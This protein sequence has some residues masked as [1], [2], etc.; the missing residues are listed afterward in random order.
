MLLFALLIMTLIRCAPDEISDQLNNS[1]T[2]NSDQ[3]TLAKAL[4]KA[5]LR[6]DVRAFL[7]NEALKQFDEDFD[8]LYHMIKDKEVSQGETFESILQACSDKTANISSITNSMPLLTIFIPDLPKFSVRSWDINASPS[9]LV[10]IRDD[11]AGA[12]LFDSN[13]GHFKMNVKDY[14]DFPVIVL[15]E[16][17]RVRLKNMQG[18]KTSARSSFSNG[19][20]QYEFIKNDEPIASNPNGRVQTGVQPFDSKIVEAYQKGVNCSNCPQ[21][22]YIYYSISPT[23]GINEGEFDD[24]YMEAI[25]EF[26]FTNTAAFE[27]ATTDWTEGSIEIHFDIVVDDGFINTINKVVYL[28]SNEYY[29][30]GQTGVYDL[31]PIT[32][33]PWRMNVYGD[34]WKFIAYEYDPSTNYETTVSHQTTKGANFKLTADGTLFKLIKVGTEFGGSI[35]QVSSSSTTM[36]YST[37]SDVLG[38]AILTWTSPI[39]VNYKTNSVGT[40]KGTTLDLNTGALL[41]SVE[42]VRVY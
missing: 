40:S 31:P 4:S 2:S 18:D 12:R 22:D 27:A 38:E 15:K 24:H 28:N 35:T 16:N 5:S 20:F 42:P 25:T 29:K 21:R 8:I 10:A 1:P 36:T 11:H 3:T 19:Q 17:E 30:I 6:A 14:P 37:G 39:L 33:A 9:P 41:I 26:H 13:G 32:I 23:E 7:K 34:R